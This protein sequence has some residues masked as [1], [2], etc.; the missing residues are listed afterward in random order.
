MMDKSLPF[1]SAEQWNSLHINKR[2]QTAAFSSQ[3]QEHPIYMN[4]YNQYEIDVKDIHPFFDT[5][6][7]LGCIGIRQQA[8]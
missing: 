5:Y 1:P 8:E 2:S 7:G 4:F 3:Q 6:A